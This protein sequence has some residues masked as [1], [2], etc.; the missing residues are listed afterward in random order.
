MM[1]FDTRSGHRTTAAPCAAT[2]TVLGAV[3]SLMFLLLVSPRGAAAQVVTFASFE[4]PT[5]E[6]FNFNNTGAT[7]TFSLVAP[8]G[9][10]SFR[11]LTS[12]GYDTLRGSAVGNNIV[13]NMT[14]TAEVSGI[15]E[16]AR[17]SV[18]Q[19]L[20]NI[21]VSFLALTSQGGLTNLVSFNAASGELSGRADST[22]FT[23]S[24]DTGIGDTLAYTSDFLRFQ[25][26]TRQQLN[27]SFTVANPT[28]NLAANNYVNSL[29]SDAG[30]TFGVDPRPLNPVVVPEAGSVWLMFFAV[31][32]LGVGLR[33]RGRFA[34][35][36]Q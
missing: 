19:P 1:S 29:A 24:V 20:R 5:A 11:Y 9:A 12:N 13:A 32:G 35:D 31:V 25:N 10:A 27:F 16:R 21:T 36:L 6:S 22:T 26:V 18:F 30:G 28:F 33:R 8:P 4:A 15:G 14:F 17:T 7:S 23:L 3:A 2:R 34:P